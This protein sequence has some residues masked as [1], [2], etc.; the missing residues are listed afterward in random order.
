[1]V[2]HSLTQ[3]GKSVSWGAIRK[4][5]VEVNKWKDIGYHYG[6]EFVYDQYEILVGRPEGS[7]AAACKE[8]KMNQRAVHICCVGNFDIAP[9]SPTLTD[10][11][12][13]LIVALMKRYK[14]PLGN[15]VGHRD[16]ASYKTCP[17]TQFNLN[18]LKVKVK[19]AL[20]S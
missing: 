13:S 1:M 17:G 7:E 4:Y 9:P 19:K 11:L 12:V 16:Y 3:D 15:I 10:K 8:G 5:H 20:T 18:E 2:H 6:V 14:I